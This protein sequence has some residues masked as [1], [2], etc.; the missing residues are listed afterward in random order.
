MLV[1]VAFGSPLR[2]PRQGALRPLWFVVRA[3]IRTKTPHTSRAGNYP[4]ACVPGFILSTIDGDSTQSIRHDGNI[5]FTV[6]L[7]EVYE[8]G[9]LRRSDC[10]N[11][12]I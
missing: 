9:L 12:W 1:A 3:S 6:N 8:Y 10:G 2:V 7:A 11:R 5:K 4:K